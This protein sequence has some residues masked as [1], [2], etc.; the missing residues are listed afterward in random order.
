MPVRLSGTPFSSM[1]SPAGTDEATYSPDT[2]GFLGLC[3]PPG[4]K[5]GTMKTYLSLGIFY[6]RLRPV[7]AEET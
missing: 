1:T 4:S 5:Q 3:D 7:V 2:A 6:A